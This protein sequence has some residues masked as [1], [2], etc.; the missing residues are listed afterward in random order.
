MTAPTTARRT[1][2]GSPVLVGV[3]LVLSL[4]GLVGT[5]WF[6]IA[7]FSGGGRSASEPHRVRTGADA[8]ALGHFRR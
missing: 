2:A 1:R 5:W 3:Y 7:F 6:N 8:G 4:V